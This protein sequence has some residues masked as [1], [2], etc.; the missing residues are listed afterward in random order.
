MYDEANARWL[1]AFTALLIP[2]APHRTAFSGGLSN[3]SLP[4]PPPL[5]LPLPPTSAPNLSRTSA[6]RSP[7]G[8]V[9]LWV[10]P[11]EFPR[12]HTQWAAHV[13]YW[14]LQG[15]E[16]HQ[17]PTAAEPHGTPCHTTARTTQR[18]THRLRISHATQE[19]RI[20][21]AKLPPGRPSQSGAAPHATHVHPVSACL[22]VS[23]IGRLP[24][25]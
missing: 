19:V 25:R 23:C 11:R 5:T 9:Q 14:S 22:S 15:A 6:P 20:Q 18:S 24:K 10:P 16:H 3:L 2:T 4:L 13:A 17:L 1:A 21:N 8:E 12:S 7:H